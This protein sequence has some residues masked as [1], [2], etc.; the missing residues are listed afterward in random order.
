M[1]DNLCL[2]VQIISLY[3]FRMLASDF[4]SSQVTTTAGAGCRSVL[5]RQFPHLAAKLADRE[6]PTQGSSSL[7]S[8]TNARSYLSQYMTDLQ[9]PVQC[10][11]AEY[12]Q[13]KLV[14]NP[15]CATVPLVA[16]YLISAP[17]SQA[18]VERLFSVCGLLTQGTRNRMEKNLYVRAWL[19][20]NFDELNDML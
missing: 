2:K 4:P 12:W 15:Q 7:N 1:L 11:A 5:V 20:V 3:S 6:A 8:A 18:F 14:A 17:A 16:Q 19:K 13:K 9:L 10:T